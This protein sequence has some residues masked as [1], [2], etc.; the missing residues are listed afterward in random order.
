MTP[1]DH[2]TTPNRPCPFPDPAG[3]EPDALASIAATLA[4]FVEDS[5]RVYMN[6][7][8]PVTKWFMNRDELASDYVSQLVEFKF[9]QAFDEGE[10]G[11][12]TG[13]DGV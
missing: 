6:D 13:D 3:L 10:L 12:G 2:Q 4:S 5:R 7:P 11:E 8:N 9:G 1:D